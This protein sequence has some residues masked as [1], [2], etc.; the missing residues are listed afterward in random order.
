LKNYELV[1]TKKAYKEFQQ[2]DKET[3]QRI[4]KCLKNLVDYYCGIEE[5]N[6]PDVR[7]LKGKYNGLFRLRVGK[8]RIIF[9]TE[10]T[11]L[12]LLIIT[13]VNRGDAYKN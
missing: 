12:V 13:I 9:K 6:A 2:L 4:R 1:W 10:V 7:R 8:Y 3:Q 11:K 5:A